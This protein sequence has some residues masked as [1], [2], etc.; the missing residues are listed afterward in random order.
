MLLLSKVLES[1]LVCVQAVEGFATGTIHSFGGCRMVLAKKKE[2]ESVTC[3]GVTIRA[4][5]AKERK[6]KRVYEGI[7]GNKDDRGG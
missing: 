2:G 6:T 7:V 5:K 3:L 1:L 4:S